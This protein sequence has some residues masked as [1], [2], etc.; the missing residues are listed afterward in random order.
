M[1]RFAASPTHLNTS[2]DN[3]REQALQNFKQDHELEYLKAQVKRME[4]PNE[5]YRLD[6]AQVP[7]TVSQPA[8]LNDYENYLQPIKLDG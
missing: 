1:G 4:S 8:L 6:D 7:R 2:L 5:N 3:E